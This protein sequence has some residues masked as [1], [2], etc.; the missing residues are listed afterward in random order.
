M[1]WSEGREGTFPSED[2]NM[3]KEAGGVVSVYIPEMLRDMEKM[4]HYITDNNYLNQSGVIIETLRFLYKKG[5]ANPDQLA[6]MNLLDF[7]ESQQFS[8][9]HIASA[10]ECSFWFPRTRSPGE[11]MSVRDI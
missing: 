1:E 4:Y 2:I 9:N 5:R 7:C 8:C 6:V 3:S 11:L 10:R